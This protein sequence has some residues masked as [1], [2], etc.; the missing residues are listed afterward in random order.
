M[1][2]RRRRRSENGLGLRVSSN[3]H[4]GTNGPDIGNRRWSCVNLMH[5]ETGIVWTHTGAPEILLVTVKGM[6]PRTMPAIGIPPGVVIFRVRL[7]R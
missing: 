3:S 4:D 6:R 1:E 5:M 2:A 7:I